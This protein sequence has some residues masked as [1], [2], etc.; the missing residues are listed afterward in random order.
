MQCR[1]MPLWSAFPSLTRR[2]YLEGIEPPLNHLGEIINQ[3]ISLMHTT[4]RD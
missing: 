1:Q 3:I 2:L 4:L